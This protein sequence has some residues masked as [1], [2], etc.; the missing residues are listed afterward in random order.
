MDSEAEV[1]ELKLPDGYRE[2]LPRSWQPWLAQLP[3]LV[4]SYLDRWE[5]T[6]MGEFPLCHSY[7]APVHRADGRPCV[8]KIQPTD[9]PEVEGARREL[10]G[11]R[12]GAPITVGVVEEDAANGVLLLDRSLPGASLEEISERDDDVATETL[13]TVIRDY[14]RPLDEPGSLGL[15]P[16]EEFADAF[17][18]FDRGPH[19]SAARRKAAHPTETRLPVLLGMDEVGTAVPV[20]R[21]ARD[22]AERVLAELL[23]DHSTPYLV[24]GDLHHGNVL[25]DDEHGF[26]VIDPWGLY[27]DRSVDAAPALH[28]PLE[29]VART[30][31]VFSLIR[32]RVAIYAEVLDV[33]WEH[34]AAWCYV[35]NVIRCLWTLEDGDEVSENDAGVRTVMALRQLI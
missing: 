31:D 24:H 22:T 35:Y 10:L 29:F 28:N 8:L 1:H 33:E 5:L 6:I 21:S 4:A 14:G 20:M 19:G 11:L 32:R 23:A 16:L 12:L 9:V 7:V 34:L 26:V 2:Q 3:E 13:A 27:G 18:R 30:T 25:A 17:E 15:R